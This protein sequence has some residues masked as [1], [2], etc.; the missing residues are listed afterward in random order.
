[1]D[2][3]LLKN[4]VPLHTLDDELLGRLAET[5]ATDDLP[6]GTV[7][8]EQ[9]DREGEAIYLLQ[10]SVELTASGSAMKRVLMGGTPDAAY[11]LSPGSPRQFTARAST[12]VRVLRIASDKL[13]RLMVFERLTT[14]V[15]TLHADGK[16]RVETDAKVETALA[17][18]A[19]F[20]NLTH[21]QLGPL[22]EALIPVKVRTGETVVKQGQAN[23]SFYVVQEGRFE[24]IHR[25]AHG[26]ERMRRTLERGASFGADALLTGA[27]SPTTVA[28]LEDGVLLKLSRQLFE[29]FLG[30]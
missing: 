5:L 20:R 9:G 12:P 8:C 23:D 13:D 4:L 1:M 24:A 6:A 19:P 10:G 7:L 22:I 18:S 25:D 3:A 30:S 28:A 11:A 15:T 16:P 29:Q 21:R 2:A 26:Q 17:G 27:P 14:I